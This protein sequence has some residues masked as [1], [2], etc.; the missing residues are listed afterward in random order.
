MSIQKF[1]FIKQGEA[2][3]G[4]FPAGVITQYLLLGRVTPTYMVSLDK[5]TWSPIS[6]FDEFLPETLPEQSP[7]NI[8]FQKPPHWQI[9][10]ISASRR[11][12]DERTR[13][14][15]LEELPTSEA[16]KRRKRIDRRMIESNEI[17][18]LR[19]HFLYQSFNRPLK[20]SDLPLLSISLGL[21]VFAML[22]YFYPVNP[23]KVDL[24]PIQ[25]DCHQA[26]KPQV[27]WKGCDMRGI[28][29]RGVNLSSSNLNHTNL[30]SVELSNSNLS[31][32]NLAN[33][34]ISYGR[35][36][37]AVLLGAN[38]KQA[39][40]SYAEL[41]GADLS[42]ADLRGAKLDGVAIVGAKLDNAVWPDGSICAPGSIG[43]CIP[44][45]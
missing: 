14:R 16:P 23:V 26:A 20:L 27:N 25:A 3:N 30:N 6:D 5:I 12:I 11:W 4:P 8:V 36:N 28:W 37:N 9:E 33:A 35:L 2:I 18:A 10:R 21:I 40:L 29:L 17:R 38:L 32:V 42:Q 22:L 39:N 15:R 41:R 44:K 43:H 24:G 7:G 13:D 1:W 45:N 31:Y 34:D 19:K